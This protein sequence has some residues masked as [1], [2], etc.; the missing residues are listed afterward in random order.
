[1]TIDTA[2]NQLYPVHQIGS[3]GFSWWIGQIEERS[4]EDPKGSGRCKVR[5]V[6]L[7]P[8]SCKIVSNEDLPWAQVMMPVTNP[9]IPGAC[10]SVSDQ[11]YEGVWVVGFFLD[12][13]KQQPMIMG[14]I[15]LVA[16]ATEQELPA[17]DMSENCRSFTTFIDNN[18]NPADQG[19]KMVLL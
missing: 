15:G 10:V 5:I 2:L 16:K 17:Q 14:S 9:H 4:K 3:D 13:D 7:H 11:L 1:M 8:Q 19:S 12:N 18:K 6:G